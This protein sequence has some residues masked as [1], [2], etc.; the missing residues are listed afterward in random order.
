MTSPHHPSTRLSRLDRILSQAESSPTRAGDSDAGQVHLASI[1]LERIR[2]L[3]IE[4]QER[5][6]AVQ[7]DIDAITMRLLLNDY[8]TAVAHLRAVT[9]GVGAQLQ[10]SASQLSLTRKELRREEEM[11]AKRA[12][13]KAED[14]E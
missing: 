1:P 7:D 11:A 13:R 14:P 12:N 4:L 6:F 5:S 8:K 2:G 10:E 9:D 3:T